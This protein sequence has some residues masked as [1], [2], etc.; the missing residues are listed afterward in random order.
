MRTG[1]LSMGETIHFEAEN[2]M[3]ENLS[4]PLH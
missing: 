4:E 1:E 2:R 3:E